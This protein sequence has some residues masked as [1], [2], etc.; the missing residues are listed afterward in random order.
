[1][2]LLRNFPDCFTKK[3]FRDNSNSLTGEIK[4]KSM[5]FSLNQKNTLQIRITVTRKS[6]ISEYLKWLK[7]SEVLPFNCPCFL[8]TKKVVSNF[9]FN[10]FWPFRFRFFILLTDQLQ[11]F[12]NDFETGR[13]TSNDEVQNGIRIRQ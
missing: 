3:H 11:F 12:L 5:R 10:C 4:Q 9:V 2:S 8:E 13:F 6:K 1:M 7:Y